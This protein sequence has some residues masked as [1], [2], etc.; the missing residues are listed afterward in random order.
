MARRNGLALLGLLVAAT[1]GLVLVTPARATD[2]TWNGA[3]TDWD[4][5]LNWN[6][7]G[8]TWPLAGD[9][10]TF[11]DDGV[12]SLAVDL[13]AVGGQFAAELVFMASLGNDYS[14]D[15][16]NDYTLTLT[17]KVTQGG[18]GD[19]IITCGV[20]IGGANPLELAVTGDG[21]LTLSGSLTGAEGLKK[22]GDG[23]A[24][25]GGNNTFGGAGKTVSVEGGTLAVQSTT[26]LGSTS[27]DVS[28]SGDATLDMGSFSPTV[29]NVTLIDGTIS[30]S[31]GTLKARSFDVRNGVIQAKLGNAAGYVASL[32]K[33]TG[34][35][36]TL[37]KPAAYTGGTFVDAGI[38]RLGASDVLPNAGTGVAG[39]VVIDGTV[40]GTLDMAAFSD[41]VGTVILK[42]GGSVTGT[43]TGTLTVAGTGR[44]W[45]VRDGSIA[46]KL[47]GAA[48]FNK[49]T[50]G[51]VTLGGASTAYTGLVDI[52]EGTLSLGAGATLGSGAVTLGSGS[53]D[54]TLQA[55]GTTS[56]AN[57]VTL[58][59]TVN[60]IKVTGAAELTQTGVIGDAAAN[61]ALTKT[62]T[63]KLIL[64]AASTHTYTGGTNINEGT[65]ALGLSDQ[66]DNGSAVA[67]S[68]GGTLDLGAN[69]D[70]VGGVT[71]TDGSITG[72]GTL[73]GSFFDVLKGA[74]SAKLAGAGAVTKT[75]A[76]T[77]ALSA[78]NTGLTG[79]VDI[80]E[81]TLSLGAGA[82]L[83]SGLVT[84]GSGSSDGTLQ[85]TG[86]ISVANAVTLAGAVNTIDVSGPAVQLTQTGVIGDAAANKALTKTGT[87][88]LILQAAGTHT[89]TGGTNILGG[90]LALGL[91]DQLADTGAVVVA[92]STLDI[93]ANSDTVGA[94]TLTSGSIIGT[95]VLTAAS[96]DLQSG[97]VSAI[98]GGGGG[99]GKSTGGTVA[100]AANN[101]F[102]GGVTISGGILQVAKD[103]ALGNPTNTINLAGGTLAA[104][105]SFVTGRN[106]NVT[107]AGSKIDVAGKTLVLSG[108]L[109]GPE[110]LEKTGAGT[111]YLTKN[112]TLG[113]AGKSLTVKQGTL[114]AFKQA[115]FGAA[116]NELIL[117]GGR[118]EVTEGPAWRG[119]PWNIGWPNSHKITIG[120]AGGT[121]YVLSNRSLILD[122]PLSGTGNLTKEC[123]GEIKI[124]QASDFSGTITMTYGLGRGNR[125]NIILRDLGTL[126]NLAGVVI[127]TNALFEAN[128]DGGSSTIERINNSAA[129]T[130]KGGEFRLAAR[131][132]GGYNVTENVGSVT[133]AAGHSIITSYRPNA[134]SIPKLVFGGNL[135]R[136]DPYF[137]LT[138]CGNPALGTVATTDSQVLFPNG[139]AL[140]TNPTSPTLPAWITVNPNQGQP[141]SWESGTRFGGYDA[142][143]GVRAA[144]ATT[145]VGRNLLVSA[146]TNYYLNAAGTVAPTAPLLANT[147]VIDFNGNT[148]LGAQKLTLTAGGLMKLQ[149]QNNT[150]INGTITSGDGVNPSTLYIWNAFAQGNQ[151]T[152]GAQI[153]DNGTGV[154]TVVKDGQGRLILNNAAGNTFS[155]GLIVNNW[156]AVAT[157]TTANKTYLGLGDVRLRQ[158]SWLDYNATGSLASGKTL[159]VE[160]MARLVLGAAP[161]VN[162]KFYVGPY[163]T[164][165]GRAGDYNNMTLGT[166]LTLATDAIVSEN[167]AGAILGASGIK[168]TWPTTPSYW[169]GIWGTVA[170]PETINVGGTSPWKGVTTTGHEQDAQLSAGTINA[171]G[172]FTLGGR[173]QVSGGNFNLLTLGGGGSNAVNIITASPI[174]VNV[175][176]RLS[177]NSNAS[178]YSGVTFVVGPD[179]QL[180]TGTVANAFGSTGTPAS[181][182]IYAGGMMNPGGGAG[183]GLS[184]MNGPVT[185]MPDGLFIVDDGALTG[186]GAITMFPGSILRVGNSAGLA[187]TQVTA[188]TL[189]AGGIFEIS[190]DNITNIGNVNPAAIYMVQ[191]G[192]R[193]MNAGYDINLNGGVLT[194]DYQNDRQIQGTG[195]INVL[196]TSTFASSVSQYLYVN[197]EVNAV[198][199]TLNIGLA[200]T[201]TIEGCWKQG[202]VRIRGKVRAGTINVNCYKGTNSQAGQTYWGLALDNPDT[203]VSGDIVVNSGHLYLGG[204]GASD[205]FGALSAPLTDR[206]GL[207]AN[208]VANRVVL[209]NG[210]ATEVGLV[211]SI[212]PLGPSGRIEVTQPF[213][214]SGDYLAHKIRFYITRREG[215][216]ALNVTLTDVTLNAGGTFSAQEDNTD[217]RY[218][219]KINSLG[220]GGVA[221]ASV[222]N[223]LSAVQPVYITRSPELAAFDGSNYALVN[224]GR[225]SEGVMTENI[226]GGIGAGV[227]VNM[228]FGGLQFQD[229]TYLNGVIDTTTAPGPTPA[230][231]SFVLVQGGQDGNPATRVTGTGMVILGKSL[232]ASAEEI[233]GRVREVATGGTQLVNVIPWVIRVKDE[234]TANT[235]VDGIIR[236]ERDGADLPV[237]GMVVFA[238]VRPD[239]GA[240]VQLASNNAVSV[241]IAN[242]SVTG[243]GARITGGGGAAQGIQ[244]VT[245]TGAQVVTMA[246]ANNLYLTGA[247]TGAGLKVGE[248]WTDPVNKTGPLPGV[249]TMLPGINLTAMGTGNGVEVAPN[250]QLF[251]YVPMSGDLFTVREAGWMYAYEAL[252]LGNSMVLE[253]DSNLTLLA[254]ATFPAAG[255]TTAANLYIGRQN[256]GGTLVLNTGAGA[257]AKIGVYG[258]DA[259][260]SASIAGGAAGAATVKFL[261]G[262][263]AAYAASILTLGDGVVEDGKVMLADLAGTDA[264]AT[265]VVIDRN[266]LIR[267]KSTYS[268]GT[269]ID[270]SDT[271]NTSGTVNNTVVVTH[272]NGL[273]TGNVTLQ[274][275]AAR[276]TTLSLC[277]ADFELSTGKKITVSDRTELRL[278]KN[279]SVDVELAGGGTLA[280]TGNV[281]LNGTITLGAGGGD[282]VFNP[283]D[284]KLTLSNAVSLGAD[285][286]RTWDVRTGSQKKGQVIFSGLVSGG[287]NSTL[288]VKGAGT[289]NLSG[290]LSTLTTLN[291]GDGSSGGV[292]VASSPLMA[293]GSVWVYPAHAYSVTQ[294]DH[295]YGEV[296]MSGSSGVIALSKDVATAAAIT[297][298]FDNGDPNSPV[299]TLALGA[300]PD[301]DTGA[302]TARKFQGTLTPDVGKILKEGATTGNEV[303]AF[304]YSLGGGGGLLV[305]DIVLGNLGTPDPETM[306]RVGYGQ[307]T[308][309]AGV[310]RLDQTNTLSGEVQVYGN[311]VLGKKDALDNASTIRVFAGGTFDLG[312]NALADVATA[313]GKLNMKPSD[314]TGNPVQGGGIANDGVSELLAGSL[315]KTTLDTLF[316]AAWNFVV[317]SGNPGGW[318]QIVDGALTGAKAFRKVGVDTVVL[319]DASGA[320]TNSYSGAA[321]TIVEGGTLVVKDTSS[322]G[323]AASTLLLTVQ[324][325][326]TLK[327]DIAANASYAGKL[328][329]K[330]QATVNIASGKTLSLSGASKLELF[331]GAQAVL[332]SG[333]L[334]NGDVAVAGSG[335]I[336]I[337]PGTTLIARY[338]DT[339]Q[340]AA[341]LFK[342]RDGATAWFKTATPVGTNQSAALGRVYPGST[343]K[344]DGGGMT[345]TQWITLAGHPG[346]VFDVDA[347]EIALHGSGAG[348]AAYSSLTYT[349]KIEVASGFRSVDLWDTGGDGD[350]MTAATTGICGQVFR[351][352]AYIEKTGTGLLNAYQTFNA[353]SPDTR[354]LGWVVSNG[355]LQGLGNDSSLGATASD[356][357]GSGKTPFI[358]RQ[359]LEY[360]EVM[361]GTT[362]AW[363]GTKGFLP[364]SQYGGLPEESGDGWNPTEFII[365]GGATLKGSDAPLV[366]GYTDPA[367]GT[368]YL[369]YPTL[370]GTGSDTPL[371][372]LGGEIN[373]RSGIKVVASAAGLADV[374]ASGNV[375]F[376]RDLA[377]GVGGID[378]GNNAPAIDVIRYLNV[379]GGSATLTQEHKALVS[380]TV[381]GATV[382]YDPGAGKTIPVSGT[383][384]VGS[385]RVQAASGTT[386]LGATVITSTAA[387]AY[388]SNLLR[389]EFYA[390][391]SSATDTGARG[392]ILAGLGGAG[393]DKYSA[394]WWTA[395]G[396]LDYPGNADTIDGTSPWIKPDGTRAKDYLGND[397]PA[398]PNDDIAFRATGQIR[399][400]IA[401]NYT[402]RTRSDDATKLWLDTGSGWQVVVDNDYIQGWTARSGTINLAAGYYDLAVGFSERASGAGFDVY[403]QPPGAPALVLIPDTQFRYLSGS[404]V[405]VDAGAA[406]N[407]GGI[408]DMARTYVIGTLG[409]TNDVVSYSLDVAPGGTATVGGQVTAAK[410][411]ISGTANVTGHMTASETINILAGGSATVGSTTVASNM[412]ATNSIN[413]GGTATVYGQMSAN[414][415]SVSGTATTDSVVG[416]GTNPVANIARTGRLNV[417]GAGGITNM[418]TL[419]TLGTTNAS[420]GP[421]SAATTTVGSATLNQVVAAGALT[422]RGNASGLTL[423]IENGS[424]DYGSYTV[425]MTG[426]I[427]VGT[428]DVN[429]KTG[430]W[431]GRITG[432][433]VDVTTPN[434]NNIGLATGP[435]MGFTSAKPPWADNETYVYTG[436]YY[437]DGG[438]DSW[439]TQIDDTGYV[440]VDGNILVSNTGNSLRMGTISGL[441][442][443]WHNV[444]IR[445]GNGTGGAGATG[446]APGVGFDITGTKLAKMEFLEANGTNV[447]YRTWDPSGPTPKIASVGQ[448]TAGDIQADKLDLLNGTASV[449]KLTLTNATTIGTLQTALGAGTGTTGALTTSGN[450]SG[451]DLLL[452]SGSANYGT[453]T[454][455]MSGTISIG[456]GFVAATYSGSQGLNEARIPGAWDIS[457]VPT[458]WTLQ[459]AG[460]RVEVVNTAYAT[461]F[462]SGTL[463][464]DNSTYVYSG[465]IIV[466]NNNGNGTGTIAFAENFDDSVLVKIDGVQYMLNTA[467]TT[468]SSPG[469]ALTL[470][471]GLHTAEFRFGQATGGIGA[472]ANG[473]W[474]TA[475][476]FGID[477]TL[478]VPGDATQANYVAPPATLF[479]VGATLLDAGKMAATG[480]LTAGDTQADK[481]DLLNGSASVGRLTV[482]QG[483]T[484][485]TL[486][487]AGQLTA[488]DTQTGKLDLV[489]GTASVGGL[490]VTNAT[491]IGTL[492]TAVATGGA[493]TGTL[494]VSGNASGKDLLLKNGSADYGAN[495]LTMTGTISIGQQY[496]APTY[497][498]SQG[499]KEARIPGAF[500]ITTLPPTWAFQSAGLRVEVVNTYYANAG[501]SAGNWI[502]NYTYVYVGE[503]NVPDNNGNGTG[504]I[505][506]AENFDDGVLV[507]ID[508]VQR[509]NDNASGTPT[510]TGGLTLSAGRHDVEFRFGQGGGAIGATTSGGWNGLLGFG[511]DTTL[512]VQGDTTQAN[513]V[514]PPASLF[515]VITGIAD[516]GMAAAA[517]TLTAGDTSANV[518][519]LI[520]GSASVAKLTGTGTNPAATIY[521]GQTL[522]ASDA[523]SGWNTLTVEGALEAGSNPI[524]MTSTG[525]INVGVGG[526]AASLT[527]G[528]TQADK[529][530]LLKGTASVGRLTLTNA[531]TIGTIQSVGQLTA[532]DTQTS[533]LDLVNG[534]ASVGSLTVTNATT[535]GT[536]QS[537]GQL[538]AADTQAGKLDLLNGT[539]SVGRLTVTNATTIG[540]SQTVG[541]LT[542]ADTQAGKLDLLNGTASVGSLTVTNATTIGTLQTALA[543]P[544]TAT[545]GALTASGNSSGT[546]LLVKNG[547]ADYGANTLAMTG[548]IS[549]GQQYVAPTMV[550]GRTQGL[551]EAYITGAFDI[552]TMPTAW[553]LQ[554]AGLRVE[555]MNTPYNDNAASGTLWVDNRTYVYVGQMNVPDNNGNGTGTIAFGE[556]FD[557]GVLVK[558]DGVERLNDNVWNVPVA[559]GA[560]T[561]AAG[562]H[563]VEFSF[564]QGGGGVGPSNSGGWNNTLGFGIDTWLPVP[565]D[566]AQGNYVA[567]PATLFSV[568]AMVVDPDHPGIAAATGTL[569]A[570][571]TSANV[572]TLI[573]GSAS[574][575]NLTGAGT[576]PAA[577]IYAGQMLAAGGLVSNWTT[578]TVNGELTGMGSATI[579]NGETLAGS[580]SVTLWGGVTV[581]AGG[582]VSPGSSA[583]ALT[584]ASMTWA[585]LGSYLWETG[586]TTGTP[587][588]D[589][590]LLRVSGALDI[591]GLSPTDKFIIKVASLGTVTGWGDGSGDVTWRIAETGGIMGTF[592]AGN[593]TINTSGWNTGLNPLTAAF[594]IGLDVDNNLTL[595]YI[596]TVL[597]Y[598]WRQ[599]PGTDEWQV[600]T[601]WETNAV[602]PA[603]KTAIFNNPPAG[604]KMPTLYASAPGQAVLGL[605]FQQAGW[606]LK[607]A[608]ETLSVGT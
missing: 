573:N 459:P 269:T 264:T 104:T 213:A 270:S 57:A 177:L 422:A 93:A 197:N 291:V 416:T 157:G 210:M 127:E 267:N 585:G 181:A 369:A 257:G 303:S 510:S 557:D 165:L 87:G 392:Q 438:S 606:T 328:L 453:N 365:H 283:G 112:S 325:A 83:G 223:G 319:P 131:N 506:F 246:G 508:G 334:D 468:P 220:S 532:A 595:S 596:H 168:G 434:P 421:V 59:G 437:S 480:M 249:A 64:Q 149:N 368:N 76:D 228:I 469:V 488:G 391:L 345:S 400:D 507:K 130:L 235:T 385:S 382:K 204:G 26:G 388:V 80:R 261:D 55:T 406:L 435:I 299:S 539:A 384:S 332:A 33:T 520:N 473:G 463:W 534:T 505:A 70:T 176:G 321:G 414:A 576:N 245:G 88:T 397:I 244:N 73:T 40:G 81:G 216:S 361:S 51:T 583:G 577:T 310:V 113:G 10:A 9:K 169:F 429:V 349:Y 599:N 600:A 232:A 362:L 527:A 308:L 598:V 471:A 477:M 605:D 512:P 191:G 116:G 108:A 171:V 32:T 236:A 565:G 27:N 30:G 279:A 186:T 458:T 179:A 100:L 418:T 129:I 23:F 475:L 581:E 218:S 47:G 327:L 164:I 60:T 568:P 74:L 119:N 398:Q 514:A 555:V 21:L 476:A 553:T 212:T 224:W 389:Q 49:T 221:D 467:S 333:T 182:I 185:I 533:A 387:P 335:T 331:A 405:Q 175:I 14:I 546:D 536:L 103:A 222:I 85:A 483:T 281:A 238:D 152:I 252:T 172:D 143:L 593:F 580:G 386:N 401:G 78:D 95:G 526:G 18:A 535:I 102:T 94:V 38:L 280:A 502:D 323:G 399:I 443:G 531:T 207:A 5:T 278:S 52:K 203:N 138:I 4:V 61:K 200:A 550:M 456:Q 36:V 341:N 161:G 430:L 433:G 330:D 301:L 135:T 567:P 43:G 162:E 360:I 337:Q 160:D 498:R 266:M 395:S 15:S 286:A 541:Q 98:L 342:V 297:Y 187:G 89:Y 371:L 343:I 274:A 451:T 445:V 491:T 426:A 572:L 24:Y 295:A 372:T 452:R 564:G 509:L 417:T 449:G 396:Q 601:N 353:T 29:A 549:L 487:S 409:I 77:V 356:W 340:Q 516:P 242:L 461:A 547:S 173:P 79:A 115:A 19:V 163:A 101:I 602:P 107:A 462:A 106:I 538:I 86:T 314:N 273:G 436:A 285:Q 156:G 126:N 62:G 563:D 241:G 41:T 271:A 189:P 548:T 159:Y 44:T 121:I 484:I 206:T 524:T 457:T 561:L 233:E 71:L 354:I 529:F 277:A 543:P 125:N 373:F 146:T 481:F 25:L 521:A 464:I 288:T 525:T 496:V 466:P 72:T 571:D 575:N 380:T 444:E 582:T 411:A 551:N 6:S 499:L 141:G 560:L 167:A 99:A 378:V 12:G 150:I 519:N 420:A 607:G 374:N 35:A 174:N 329:L 559:T 383:L 530:N 91:G 227:K 231:S 260:L 180:Y 501:A 403:W 569:T 425:T 275:A 492:Q 318:T 298:N 234:G 17:Q 155:G 381:N 254:D 428:G 239:A 75:T 205:Q 523:V 215:A 282:Q 556:N 258:P 199:Q 2:Y 515:T 346:L 351:P 54:A 209:N 214:L 447:Q 255:L 504:T 45:D 134:T 272:K 423:N 415:L 3:G 450:S 53:S 465:Q 394:Q 8:G 151:L 56:L 292:V 82:T 105:A 287:G 495:T 446:G 193:T 1:L 517:G 348:S 554:P 402:F 34:G 578:L 154:V 166:N 137:T 454:L 513:Y 84:L 302:M 284:N 470:S 144:T 290:G 110:S 503:I 201:E 117:D 65:L 594:E 7:A 37:S 170:G 366:L 142:T 540:T 486:Q 13:G 592:D 140:L 478:P 114:S 11:N 313:I 419:T 393:F 67:I 188:S 455:T 407:A 96:Y 276:R 511:I 431:A 413:V 344:F 259:S 132:A 490:T 289:L 432:S 256:Y 145:V 312:G 46:A 317:G 355:T 148:D 262:M 31:T 109:G 304:V 376:G 50:S 336:D 518:L 500:D 424:A 522:T 608:T 441:T 250:G 237:N 20:V 123:T 217:V 265:A 326:S 122:A 589:W 183:T 296:V 240:T 367:T 587:G 248:G 136:T 63:G 22:T 460:L 69:S 316:P 544:G 251:V 542:A 552:T 120:P 16:A 448:F 111:L 440:K 305:A 528:D 268:G 198:G 590:D 118:L 309:A 350:M 562:L 479:R 570:G 442:P 139:V 195:K 324:G 306:L 184:S 404:I 379:T 408:S 58:A 97:T 584:V 493:T 375:R 230:G 439:L 225:M 586:N 579:G 370:T 229:G 359:H 294:A 293:A 604:D 485:G 263:T 211:G 92:G 377:T 133:L 339:S 194:Q 482:A 192:T 253:K 588:V 39:D 315:D 494:T 178:N 338:G 545:T 357:A 300:L 219:L 558:I 190:A 68:G 390:G 363:R 322:L 90:T 66:L 202:N 566:T 158:A 574:V 472:N 48:A 352:A 196:G 153:T 243:S 247:W 307:G 347:A 591:T 474:T 320:S 537:V 410:V 603:D 226:Y 427:T 28:V 147:L 128:N 358:R 42:N 208:R 311:L 412:T 124:F 364:A 489:N 497:S 597:F